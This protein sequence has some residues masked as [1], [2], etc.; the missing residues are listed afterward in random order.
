[1]H[2]WLQCESCGA[3]T[4]QPMEVCYGPLMLEAILTMPR[5]KL[6]PWTIGWTFWSQKPSGSIDH[7]FYC[8]QIVAVPRYKYGQVIG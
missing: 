7:P 6:K 4:E 3:A 2:E 8:V 1:M 5:Y